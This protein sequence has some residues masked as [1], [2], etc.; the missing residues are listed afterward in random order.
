MLACT[1]Y[2]RPTIFFFLKLVFRLK[3]LTATSS[4]TGNLFPSAR[5]PIHRRQ[6]QASPS[7]LG[8][9]NP[10]WEVNVKG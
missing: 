6:L 2:K 4:A 7:S 3:N 9:S 10:R 5:V 8:S 1:D